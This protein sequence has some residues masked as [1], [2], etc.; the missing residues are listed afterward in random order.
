MEKHLSEMT[1]EELTAPEGIRCS[2]GKTHR[3]GLAWFKTGAGVLRLLPEA[4]EALGCGHPFVVIDR[5]TK[6]A[7]GDRVTELRSEEHTSELQ[8]RI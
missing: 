5:N 2:C 7:A 8:S 6:R 1:L 3:C 4:L